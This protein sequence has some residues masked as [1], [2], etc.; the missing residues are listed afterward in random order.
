[1]KNR[2][3]LS[4]FI[5]ITSCTAVM[6]LVAFG[7]GTKVPGSGGVPTTPGSGTGIGGLGKGPSAVA[8]GG[9]GGYILLAQTAITNVT[10]SAITGNVGLSPA[11]GA[12][13]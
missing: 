4:R 8:L 12:G 11:T 13:I 1:M 10:T 6:L 3:P 7:C 9:A 5:T 2:S